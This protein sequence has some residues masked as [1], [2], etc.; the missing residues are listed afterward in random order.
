MLAMCRRARSSTLAD[1]A[2]RVILHTRSEHISMQIGI[3]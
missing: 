1:S 3:T 2:A